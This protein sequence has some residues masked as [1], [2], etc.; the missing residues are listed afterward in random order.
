ML[1]PPIAGLDP[2]ALLGRWHIA[3]TTLGFWRGRSDATVEY[4]ARADGR[5]DDTLRFRAGTRERALAGLD[6]PLPERPG[7]FRWRGAGWLAWC[8]STWGFV[9]LDP[10]GAWAVTWFSRATLGVT[11]EGMDVYGRAPLAE[12]ALQRVLEEIRAR[13]EL[14]QLDGWFSIPRAR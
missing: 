12:A 8:T 9:A 2:R 4:A 14:P 7:F 5:W 6:T 11:P 1:P 3:A 13:P 10:A